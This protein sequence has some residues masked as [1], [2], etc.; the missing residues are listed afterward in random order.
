MAKIF[1]AQNRIKDLLVNAPAPNNGYFV[2]V[3]PNNPVK[4]GPVLVMTRREKN[5]ASIIDESLVSGIGAAVVIQLPFG[6]NEGIDNRVSLGLGFSIHVVE[7]VM[8]NQSAGAGTQK[9]AEEILEK[10]I[11]IV[12]WQPL[13]MTTRMDRS[14]YFKID[15]NA[16]KQLS[17]PATNPNLLVYRIAV[18]I[19]VEPTP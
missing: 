8:I 13:N 14:S 17:A 15:K 3:R 2:G 7:N 9:P 16:F 18:N 11:A 6:T 1:D 12:H 4:N 19:K 5:A 10:V